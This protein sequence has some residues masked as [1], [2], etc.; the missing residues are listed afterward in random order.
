M[1]LGV[2]TFQIPRQSGKSELLQTTGVQSAT[3]SQTPVSR[4]SVDR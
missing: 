4:L 1:G 2:G 3:R